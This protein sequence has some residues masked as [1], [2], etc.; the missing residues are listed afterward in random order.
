MLTIQQFLTQRLSAISITALTASLLTLVACGGGGGSSEPKISRSSSSVASIS[1]SNSSSSSSSSELAWTEGVYPPADNYWSQCENPRTGI[2]PYNDLPY[3][4]VQGSTTA[5]NFFL[6]SLTNELY[7]WYDEVADVNPALYSTPEYFQL[8]KTTAVTPTGTA[9]DQYH[10]SV[11]TAEHYKRYES[12]IDAGYGAVWAHLSTIPPRELAIAYI[13]P[14]SP[15]AAAGLSRGARVL[16]VDG[17]DLVNDNTNAGINTLNT[18]LFAPGLNE[19]HTFKVRD[20]NASTDRTIE[21]TATE[22]TIDTTPTVKIINTATGKVGYLLFTTHIATAETALTQAIEQFRSEG[23]SDLVLDLR[24]NGGGYLA[25]ANELAYMV[26]GSNAANKIFNNPEFN[27]KYQDFDPFTGEALEPEKFYTKTQGFSED[28]GQ[29]LPTLDL[30]RVY[31]LA[32]PN[33][34]SASESVINSLVGIDVEVVQIGAAT[35]GKPYGARFIDNCG[36]SYFTIQIK[37]ANAKGY[38]DYSDG[39]FPGNAGSS[40]PAEL[41]GCTVPDDYGHLLGEENEA[42]LAVALHYRDTGSCPTAASAS[43]GE[44]SQQKAQAAGTSDGVIQ[45]PP[46]FNDMILRR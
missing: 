21:M 16:E 9:K 14:D 11:P 31:I 42:R 1:S 8:M 10:Y 20:L 22:V 19:T 15:A 7:L 36:S 45:Q 43:K 40:N 39:F 25:I 35:C 2:A 26:A 37:A 32:G 46:G 41:P 17:V 27:D 18:G 3:P 33:T 28:A 30:N 24:Y 34:C 29:A 5:E 44:T 38:G 13:Y 4:D 23:V 6:R 12:G